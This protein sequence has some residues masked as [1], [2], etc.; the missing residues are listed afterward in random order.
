MRV[1][2]YPG[3]SLH[4]VAKEYDRSVHRVA[5]KLGVELEELNDWNCCGAMEVVAVNP[6]A[7]EGIVARN[8]A[9]AEKQKIEVLAAVCPACSFQLIST[10]Q[11]MAQDNTLANE[12]NSLL[13]TPYTPNSVKSMHFLQLLRDM[14]GIESIKENIVKGNPLEG[15]KGVAYYGCFCTRPG[16]IIQFE[17]PDNPTFMEELIE[18]VGAKALYFPMKTKCCGATQLLVAKPTVETLTGNIIVN[19]RDVGA[20]FIVVACQ[21]CALALDGQQKQAIKRVKGGKFSIPVLYMSQVLGLGMGLDYKSLGL[22]SNYVSPKNLLKQV[23][24]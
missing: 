22:G 8:L 17:D 18:A 14:I 12:I 4:K 5:E 1:G 19:A 21:M 20:D 10:N 15:K 16:D 13:D 7:A 6:L 24:T 11:K 23:E 2:Y 3:C 9:I